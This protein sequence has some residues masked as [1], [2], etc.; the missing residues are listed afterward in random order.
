MIGLAEESFTKDVTAKAC[1][2]PAG[3]ASNNALPV[4]DN[5]YLKPKDPTIAILVS[6]LERTGANVYDV[7]LGY[8]ICLVPYL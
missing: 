7:C 6:V 1:T 4:F 3:A 2:G 8:I 5:S